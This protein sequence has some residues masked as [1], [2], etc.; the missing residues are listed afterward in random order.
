MRAESAGEHA[1]TIGV[2]QHIAGSAAG[3]PD[4]AGHQV[5]PVVNILQ[6]VANHD[7]FAGGARGRMQTSDL[8]ARDGKKA[9]GI[10]VAKI[11][12][13]HER[14]LRQIGQSF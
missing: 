8:V 14:K 9:K 11:R 10:V 1:I 4:G 3:R 2:V 13:G 12:L 5:G 7:R 6:C